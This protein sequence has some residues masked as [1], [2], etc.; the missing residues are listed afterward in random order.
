MKETRDGS[1]LQGPTVAR[2]LPGY[3]GINVSHQNKMRYRSLSTYLMTCTSFDFGVTRFLC[4]K[5]NRYVF[6]LDT[7]HNEWHHCCSRAVNISMRSAKVLY[8]PGCVQ[9]SSISLTSTLSSYGLCWLSGMVKCCDLLQD[10][11]TVILVSVLSL[12]EILFLSI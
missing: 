1:L 11:E 5:W 4:W 10:P 12:K 9:A 3:S 8:V 6:K 2:Y 7:A